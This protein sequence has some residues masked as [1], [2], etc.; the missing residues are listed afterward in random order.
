MTDQTNTIPDDPFA[1]PATGDFFDWEA[2]YNK[3]TKKGDLLVFMVDEYR[4]HLPTRHTKPGEKSPAIIAD[5]YVLDGEDEG[6]VYESTMV[7]G[8]VMIPQ[9]KKRVGSIVL[10]RLSQGVPKHGKGSEPW[11]LATVEPG[12]D[13]HKRAMAWYAE[14]K[15]AQE[16]DPFAG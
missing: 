1:E 11:E 3:S 14:W 16:Q 5:I 2:H 6:G 12:T 15:A 13:D 4:D 10:A 8:R 7:F 9:L